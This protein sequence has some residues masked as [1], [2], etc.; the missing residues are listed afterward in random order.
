VS[1]PKFK[2]ESDH[3]LNKPL[4][5]MGVMKA[6]GGAAN[7]SGIADPANGPLSTG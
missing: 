4:V 7:L 3:D 2:V 5:N 6:F 1:I